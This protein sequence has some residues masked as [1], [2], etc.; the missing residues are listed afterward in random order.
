M[1][2]FKVLAFFTANAL[3]TANP[4]PEESIFSDPSYLSTNFFNS[5]G[6]ADPL[7]DPTLLASFDEGLNT[8]N[9][10]PIDASNDGSSLSLKISVLPMASAPLI[11]M[12]RHVSETT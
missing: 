12:D 9:S 2:F 8:I 6:A 4:I 10:A 11:P 1:R 3:T 7:G 5:D